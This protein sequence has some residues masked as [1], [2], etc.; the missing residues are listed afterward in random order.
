MPSSRLACASALLATALAAALPAQAETVYGLTAGATTTLVSF[1]SANPTSLSVVGPV[2]GIINGLSLR[3]IDFRPADGLLYGLATAGNQGQLYTID[4]SN[5]VASSV[6]RGFSFTGDAGLSVSIDFNPVVD[7]LRVVADNGLNLRLNPNT[8]GV[9]GSDTALSAAGMG[10]VAYI[11]NF[12]GATQTTLY[13]FTGSQLVTIGG[14]HGVPSPNSG[15][16][17]AV[18][19]T[20]ASAWDNMNVGFDIGSSGSAY[21]SFDDAASSSFDSEFYKINLSNGATTFVGKLP[22]AMLDIAVAVPE[23]ET[24]ALWLAGL[25]VMGRVAWR[26]RAARN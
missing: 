3:A 14:I 17:N 18:G 20:G 7:R 15:L 25:A 11:N 16:V 9:A 22:V 4:L 1:D 2:S 8:G 5:G 12:V 6:G 24:T 26:R 21:L 19:P 10:D 13:G 23:P